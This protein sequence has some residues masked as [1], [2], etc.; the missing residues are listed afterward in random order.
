MSNLDRQIALLPCL[1]QN[2]EYARARFG[3]DGT[4]VYDH[5]DTLQQAEA[6]TD[7]KAQWLAS[8]NEATRSEHT[9]ASFAVASRQVW[10][11]VDGTNVIRPWQLLRAGNPDKG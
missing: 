2:T 7:A 3:R 1:S 10:I 9:A 5:F 11:L 4:V 6:E 8:L